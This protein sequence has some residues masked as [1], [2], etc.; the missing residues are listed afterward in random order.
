[1]NER[2]VEQE[3]SHRHGYSIIPTERYYGKNSSSLHLPFFCAIRLPP[4]PTE[5]P[6]I[7]SLV[8]EACGLKIITGSGC[9]HIRLPCTFLYVIELLFTQAE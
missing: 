2:K 3:D 7:P 9:V 5:I 6:I 1:M 8:A 4:G